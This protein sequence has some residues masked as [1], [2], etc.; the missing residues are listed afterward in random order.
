MKIQPAL[1]SEIPSVE[2]SDPFRWLC[3]YERQLISGYAVNA[4][5]E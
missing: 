2:D 5:A 1:I 3:H 4:G